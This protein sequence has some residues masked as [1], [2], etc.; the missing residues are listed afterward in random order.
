M[1]TEREIV[2]TLIENLADLE[3]AHGVAYYSR[4][5]VPRGALLGVPRIETRAAF[6]AYLA[7]VDREPMANW[8]HSCRYLLIDQGTGKEVVSIEGQLPPFTPDN[9][10][11]WVLAYK[12]ES[13]PDSAVAVPGT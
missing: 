8:S 12:A 4:E 2:T 3:R 1:L 10:G 9:Q 7:F 13:V 5:P 6:D 11:R